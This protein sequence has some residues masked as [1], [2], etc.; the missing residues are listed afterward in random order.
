MAIR[1]TVTI[2]VNVEGEGLKKLT[3]DAKALKKALHGVEKPAKKTGSAFAENAELAERMRSALG[4]LGDM[5][6]DITGGM[7]DLATAL[8]TFSIAQAGI[9]ASV[10]VSIGALG[11]FAQGIASTITQIDDMSGAL[12]DR[13]DPILNT[14][15]FR[16]EELNDKLEHLS[17]TYDAQWVLL[18]SKLTPAIGGFVTTLDASIPIVAS[19]A[20]SAANAALELTG[21][22]VAFKSFLSLM[23][24][25]D[26]ASKESEKSIENLGQSV[27]ELDEDFYSLKDEFE[28][29][30]QSDELPAHFSMVSDT[31][32]DLSLMLARLELQAKRTAKAT[33]D[34]SKSALEAIPIQ[35]TWTSS[36]G[37]YHGALES[38]TVEADN[39]GGAY[40][41][42]GKSVEETNESMGEGTKKFTHSA[43]DAAHA[44]LNMTGSALSQVQDMYN[45][46]MNARISTMRKGSAEHKKM[47]RKQFAVNKAMALAT[48]A[49]N[50][51]GAI[52]QAYNSGPIW[53]GIPAAIV[54]GA[55]GAVQLGMIAA[56]QPNFHRGGIMPDE[57]SGFGGRAT[58][59]QNEAEVVITAQGQRSFADA[60]NAMN[61]GDRG[62][63]GGV[64]VMLDSEPI[65]G[66]VYAMGEADPSY[67][68]RRRS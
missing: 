22:G 25:V 11:K 61:R 66:V 50:L 37:E 65:R 68:H 40:M 26:G 8:G 58:T 53:V 21:I 41:L 49:V 6:G 63:G 9:A 43:T 13:Q 54:V 56:Q 20:G 1:E 32:H 52:L 24:L 60:V 18:T 45:Q 33:K 46:E 3:F 31:S 55:L 62:A 42:I 39:F 17:V 29:F 35:E 10:I 36:L 12:R 14:A 47:M 27:R 67:G 30:P 7:D 34:I 2:E 15:I 28:Q 64:T 16:I 4:P 38:A 51:A 59:R 48:A 23:A 44:Y 5:L 57:R 19:F